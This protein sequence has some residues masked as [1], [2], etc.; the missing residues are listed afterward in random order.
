MIH[1]QVG[2]ICLAFVQ[3]FFLNHSA[4]SLVGRIQTKGTEFTSI[5]NTGLLDSCVSELPNMFQFNLSEK[6]R[7]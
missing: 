7:N 6:K 2:E 5:L 1:V 4:E 3:D